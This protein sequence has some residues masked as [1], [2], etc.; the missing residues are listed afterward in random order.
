MSYDKTLWKIIISCHDKSHCEVK[1][2]ELPH[3]EFTGDETIGEVVFP[4]LR[5]ELLKMKWPGYGLFA[6][7]EPIHNTTP[8]N[9]INYQRKVDGTIILDCEDHDCRYRAITTPLIKEKE[10]IICSEDLTNENRVTPMCFHSAY[11]KGCFATLTKC[12]ICRKT[13]ANNNILN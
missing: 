1:K 3:T 9:D 5:E 11:C 7:H 6:Q 8:L 10:C 13:F 4:T 2:I 12:A